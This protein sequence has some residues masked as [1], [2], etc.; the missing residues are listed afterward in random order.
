MIKAI[1]KEPRN[2]RAYQYRGAIYN[3]M[4]I[5]DKAMADTDKALSIDPR[6]AESHFQKSMILAN[7]GQKANAQAALNT[8]FAHDPAGRNS[9][10]VQNLQSML[11][12]M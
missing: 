8:Y 9:R 4:G 6:D 11:S 3:E 2:N 5:Y 7:M 1:E 12:Q 10:K